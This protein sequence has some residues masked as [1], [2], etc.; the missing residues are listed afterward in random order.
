[1]NILLLNSI[2]RQKFGGGE[3]W[4]IKAACALTQAGHRVVIA[5]RRCSDL[6]N[7]AK[8]AGLP[9]LVM[10]IRSEF[11][12][13]NMWRLARFC[14][15]DRT[16]VVLCAQNRDA[17]VAGLT[18]RKTAR[19]LVMVR[20]GVALFAQP[21]RKNRW[22]ATRLL[23]GLITNTVT[24]QRQYQE[25]GWFPENFIRVVYN[26]VENKSAVVPY[27]FGRDFP[28]KKVIFAAGRLAEQKGFEYLIEA[29]RLLQQKRS[30]LIFIVTGR[31][32]LEADLKHRIEQY[33]LQNSFFLWGFRNDID[34]CLKGCT[35]F[36][37]PSLFEG[38][39]NAVMEAMACGAAVVAT[40][41]NGVRELLGDQGTGLIIPPRDPAALAKA[42]TAIVDQP[43]LRARMGAYGMAR[44]RERFTMQVMVE[45][46]EK[47]FQERLA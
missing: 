23:D 4:M 9:S 12:P 7:S 25:Y 17:W 47:F 19:P 24:I 44:V 13:L 36:I 42:I 43:E 45:N 21:S 6:L 8:A 46:L 11:S 30:D 39:P 29:A 16:D 18:F 31:G 10:N 3:K 41:V 14:K 40:D 33:G 2:G 35:L 26:G 22:L 28:G 1:M 15:V 37:L 27:Y 20:H 5:G 32:R 38:M 34:P